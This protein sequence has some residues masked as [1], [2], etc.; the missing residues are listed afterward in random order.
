M[1]APGAEKPLVLKAINKAIK[2]VS[3]DLEGLQFNTAISSLMEFLNEAGSEGVSRETLE[4]FV[5]LLSPLAPHIG[6][7]L[8]QRLGHDNTLA[9]EAW[10]GWD[11]ALLKEGTVQVVV[12][13]GGK[14][15]GL[16]EVSS[17]IS[18][19]ELRKEIISQMAATPYP[20]G[21]GDQFFVVFQGG[22]KVPKLVNVV[23]K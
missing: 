15:R 5:L 2:R 12:Q 10:P 13:I 4:R 23:K 7:E 18:E 8:W 22:T 21:E 16:L 6:E 11:E 17:S 1:V 20:V 3:T 9:Y 14:K 19:E